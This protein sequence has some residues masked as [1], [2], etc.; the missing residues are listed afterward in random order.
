MFIKDSLIDMIYFHI[1]HIWFWLSDAPSHYMNQCDLDLCRHMASP[2][3]NELRHL[4]SPATQLFVQQLVLTNN[5]ENIKA[6]HYQ[7]FVR[8]IHQWLA[9]YF[10]KAPHSVCPQYRNLSYGITS[11][12]DFY[13][14]TFPSTCSLMGAISK[15]WMDH[16]LQTKWILCR[17]E[18][19]N[20]LN[21]S[22]SSLKWKP[23]NI[24]PHHASIG[25]WNET[26]I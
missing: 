10:Y 23:V 8:G 7:P 5:K 13:H 22:S 25:F 6:S 2:C 15:H 18:N 26:D 16:P 21:I 14:C 19:K 4:Q 3:H 12:C 11:S 20:I 24:M 9:N 1:S 17:F